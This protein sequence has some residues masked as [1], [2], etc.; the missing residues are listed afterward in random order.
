MCS[1]YIYKLRTREVQ[2]PTDLILVFNPNLLYAEIKDD[3]VVF[4]DLKPQSDDSFMY[5]ANNAAF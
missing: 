4:E 1:T 2:V 5:I 3:L